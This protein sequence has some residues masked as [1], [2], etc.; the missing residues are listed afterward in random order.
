MDLFWQITIVEF[1]LNIAVFAAAAIAY[2]PIHGL[3]E[4]LA[5]RSPLIDGLAIGVLFGTTTALALLMPIHLNGG[6][7]IG[8]QTVL[9]ALAGPLGGWAAALFSSAIAALAGLFQWSGGTPFGR[10]CNQSTHVPLLQRSRRSV[11]AYD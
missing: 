8:G 2:G 3:V 4:R 7:S 6:A 1:L 11:R 9:L 10:K 5:G